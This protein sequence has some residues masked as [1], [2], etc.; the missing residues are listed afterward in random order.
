MVLSRKQF[1]DLANRLN[2][3]ANDVGFT[4]DTKTGEEPEKGFTVA[5]SGAEKEVPGKVHD[6]TLVRYETKERPP[7][8]R[9]G[10]H[11][12]GYRETP[13]HPAYLDVVQVFSPREKHAA[14]AEILAEKQQA[15]WVQHEGRSAQN[16]FHPRNDPSMTDADVERA[17][18]MGRWWRKN[19]KAGKRV[20]DVPTSTLKTALR[21]RYEIQGT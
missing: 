5:K 3:P 16:V 18:K 10:A 1:S 2:Q 13:G 17:S 7:L 9:M 14:Y 4:V 6:T 11:M 12:G 19:P 20:R 21:N 15:G 8:H